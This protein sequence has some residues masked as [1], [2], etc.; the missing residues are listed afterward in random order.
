MGR[1]MADF[2]SRLH[3]NENE[4]QL[5]IIV[6]HCVRQSEI[7]TNDDG[8]MCDKVASAFVRR[9]HSYGTLVAIHSDRTVNDPFIEGTNL[10]KYWK[11]KGFEFNDENIVQCEVRIGIFDRPC[12]NKK[13]EEK[14]EAGGNKK[15]SHSALS[16]EVV[17]KVDSKSYIFP[18]DKVWRLRAFEQIK[19]FEQQ[20]IPNPPVDTSQRVFPFHAVTFAPRDTFLAP[21]GY[22][23]LSATFSQLGLRLVWKTKKYVYVGVEKKEICALAYFADDENLLHVMKSDLDV[24]T[25]ISSQILNKPC[26]QVTLTNYF[27]VTTEEKKN[28]EFILDGLIRGQT[29]HT[30]ANKLKKNFDDIVDIVI[31]FKLKFPKSMQY[32]EDIILTCCRR[33][34]VASLLGRRQYLKNTVPQK[35]TYCENTHRKIIS[36]L[37]KGSETDIIKCAMVKIYCELLVL[38]SSCSTYMLGYTNNSLF[39]APS[40]QQYSNSVAKLVLQIDNELLFEVKSENFLKVTVMSPGKCICLIFIFFFLRV[41]YFSNFLKLKFVIHE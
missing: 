16:Q 11:E 15:D 25:N 6:A 32:L 9:A 28:V 41:V 22:V 27:V 21:L 33:G 4:L 40:F 34:F 2:A 19:K 24:I 31:K 5:D 17:G 38:E 13:E 8:I 1:D 7:E 3:T 35:S 14:T 26:A 29:Y 30:I 12:V 23:F 36:T 39:A 37:F 20:L 10:A 18:A